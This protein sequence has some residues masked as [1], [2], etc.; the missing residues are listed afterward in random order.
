MNAETGLSE[1]QRGAPFPVQEPTHPS[2]GSTRRLLVPRE[3]GAWG[4]VSLPFLAGMLVGGNWLHWRTLAAAVAVFSI[5]LLR[6][7]L[8]FFWRFQVAAN[9]YKSNPS[10]QPLEAQKLQE[11]QNA[12][13]SLWVYGLVAVAAGAYLMTVLPLGPLLLLGSGATLLTLLALYF[14]AHNY[15]RTPALQIVIAVGLTSSA[16]LSYL[17]ARGQWEEPALWIWALSAAHSAA[18]G[19]EVHARLEA[20]L[21]SRKPGVSS[22]VARRNA[23]L[24]QAALCFL[25]AV[26][27]VSGRPWLLLPFIPP[28]ALHGWELWQ[29]RS[30]PVPRISMHRVGWMQLGAS[31]AFCFLL[32]AVLR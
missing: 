14:A 12:R 26:L 1:K 16:L 9:K 8:L 21:A 15:Q 10:L 17:A 3:H 20:I 5:F 31:I 27:A 32:V 25:L 23:L 30:G 24:A 2:P 18:S 7:P 28:T 4:M 13:F 29:F 19:M 11:I 6:E 22:G